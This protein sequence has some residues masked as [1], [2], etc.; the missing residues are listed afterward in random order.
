M[1]STFVSL[2]AIVAGAPFTI[3]PAAVAALPAASAPAIIAS[4]P[5]IAPPIAALK[6]QEKHA[7]PQP[8]I[9]IRAPQEPATNDAP[10]AE[11]L[12]ETPVVLPEPEP[13]PAPAEPAPSDTTMPSESDTS[14]SVPIESVPVDSEPVDSEPAAEAAPIADPTFVSPTEQRA[15]L[16]AAGGAL[17]SVETAQGR[18]TQLDPTGQ[19][20]T[21]SFALQRPGRM[22]F[23]Y[24]APVP[25]LIAAD[26][27]TVAV[28]DDEL[29]T[30]DRVPL[31]ATPLNL[32]L[33]DR[34]D[35]ETEAEVLRVIKAN[36]QVAITMRDRSGEADGELTLYLD[37]ASYD[38]MGWRTLDGNDR[39]TFVE[40]RDVDTG[41]SLNPRLFRIEEFEDEDDDRR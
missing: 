20:A 2:A 18:F 1:I 17:S 10:A 7:R 6:D 16:K 37:S 9:Q 38:L 23:D 40:L 4:E 22:R 3:E 27:A 31:A 26:G 14:D 34:L 12:P 36:G 24:D 39:L 13:E 35:F 29:E 25:I 5:Q 8:L 33:D 30:V 41:V 28:R 15:I 11:V 32:L 19:R 21:G